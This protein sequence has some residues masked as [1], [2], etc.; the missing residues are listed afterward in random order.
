M[1]LGAAILAASLATASA[2]PDSSGATAA[3]SEGPFIGFDAGAFWLQGLSAGSG[4]LNVDVKFKTNWGFDVPIGYNFGNGFSLSISAGYW[5]SHFSS[6]TGNSGGLSQNAEVN[7]GIAFIPVMFNGAYK[8]NLSDRFHWYLGAGAGAVHEDASFG[9][10]DPIGIPS[11]ISYGQ[12]GGQ[13]ATFGGMT[14]S[15]WDFGFQLFTGFSFDITSNVSL[16]VGY[17]F[18]H[19]NSNISVN[20]SSSS[21]FNGSSV[22]VGLGW[23]F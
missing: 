8:F 13:I 4:P 6:V 15:T 19:V 5:D 11:S 16:G 12:L 10:Y 7:G 9:A 14:A 20:G 3:S 18:L 21:D 22:E 17:R 2:G 23:K 1:T